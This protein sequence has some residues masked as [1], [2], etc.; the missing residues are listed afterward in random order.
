M[1]LTREDIIKDEEL[2]STLVDYGFKR[3]GETYDS[4]EEAVDSFLED[5]RAIQSNTIS[6]AK[7]MNFVSNLNDNDKEETI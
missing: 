7:F 4:A 6:T 5:Y 2:V 3:N 1:S